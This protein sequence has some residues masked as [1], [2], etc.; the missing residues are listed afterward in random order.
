M[1][2]GMRQKL[3]FRGYQMAALPEFEE[4]FRAATR[5]LRQANLP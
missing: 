2:D 1:A 4:V 3:E 5:P